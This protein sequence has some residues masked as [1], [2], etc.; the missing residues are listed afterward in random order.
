MFVA[1]IKWVGARLSSL[2]GE[3][4]CKSRQELLATYMN[5][6][7]HSMN[8]LFSAQAIRNNGLMFNWFLI[9]LAPLSNDEQLTTYMV[10][11]STQLLLEQLLLQGITLSTCSYLLTFHTSW[12]L[13]AD[14]FGYTCLTHL[15]PYALPT[16]FLLIS[17]LKK[18]KKKN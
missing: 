2:T 3:E 11:A 6:L 12:S 17:L 9:C 18:K 10:H 5:Q 15:I 7:K 4:I 1:Q 14:A 13:P 16:M 8:H